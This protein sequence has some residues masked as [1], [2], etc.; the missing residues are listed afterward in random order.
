MK[1]EAWVDLHLHTNFSDG[2]LTPTQVVMKAKELGLRAIGIVDHD[3]IDGIAEAVEA[4]SRVGV[5][6]VSGVELSTQF[7]GRDVHILAY[8]FDPTN[9]HLMEYLERFQEGRY[10]RAAKMIRNL[11]HLGIRLTMDEVEERVKGRSIGRPHLAEVL[12]EK[13][14]VETFQEAFQRYIG[15]GS[16]AYEE[17]YKI[18]PEEAIGLISEAKGLSFLAHPGYFISDEIIFHFVKAGLD[19][20]EIVHPKLSDNRTRHLQQLARKHGVLVSGGSDCHGGR[21]GCLFIGHYNVPYTILKEMK[22][23]LWSRWDVDWS[24]L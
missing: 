12:M 19:G 8:Y 22:R 11:N 3:T 23:V 13:G 1:Q 14:Y 24:E 17:K 5:E 20:I 7:E 4:G 18:S 15:Y 10:L 21:D 2:I 9:P 6:I 16:L